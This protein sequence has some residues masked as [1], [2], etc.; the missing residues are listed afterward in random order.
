MIVTLQIT[1]KNGESLGDLY[2]LV[3]QIFGKK[4]EEKWLDLKLRRLEAKETWM[5]IKEKEW[6]EWMNINSEE[7]FVYRF[8]GDL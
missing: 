4:K 6:R 5:T 8:E 1:K 2:S 3:H 7:M